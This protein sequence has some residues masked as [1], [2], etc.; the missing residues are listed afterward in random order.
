MI[1][2]LASYPKSGN[3]WLRMF[4]KSYFLKSDEESFVLTFDDG[5]KEHLDCARY[6]NKIGLNGIFFPSHN[7]FQN[8]FLG[9]VPIDTK[10]RWGFV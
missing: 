9:K 2:W 4:L 8:Q 1:I 7:I 3:T 5:Y 10:V 6:L